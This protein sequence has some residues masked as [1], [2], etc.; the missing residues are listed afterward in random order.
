MEPIRRC[1]SAETNYIIRRDQF[2]G[3]TVDNKKLKISRL[4][5]VFYDYRLN[6]ELTE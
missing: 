6:S 5:L 1:I 3:I 4:P 2:S